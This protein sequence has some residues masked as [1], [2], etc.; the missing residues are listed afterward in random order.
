M[1]LV[2]EKYKEK[3][4]SGQARC[5]HP[6]EY[7]RFRSACMIHFIERDNKREQRLRELEKNDEQAE[8]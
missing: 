2:C 7:C 4:D 8:V 6:V 3:V 5:S 1:D